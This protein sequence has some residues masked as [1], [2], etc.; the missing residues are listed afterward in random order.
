MDLLNTIAH[1]DA[2][3]LMALLDDDSIDM[4][5]TSPP[6][7]NLRTY[8]GHYEFDFE[9]IAHET[10]RVLKPGGVLVWVVGD[11]TINGSET[12]TSMRQALYFVDV[13]GFKMHDTM[14]YDKY[15]I[16]FPDTNRYHQSWEY[17][18]VLSKNTPMVFNPQKRKNLYPDDKK[19]GRQRNKD[20]TLTIPSGYKKKNKTDGW[21]FNVWRMSAGYMKTTKDKEAYAH[22]AM[23]PEKLAE[24]HILT[25]SNPGDV[26]MDYFMGSGTTAKMAR[27]NGRHYIGCDVNLEYVQ[28]ARQRLAKP[29]TLS[30]FDEQPAQD[31][32]KAEQL[33][34]FGDGE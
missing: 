26:V 28:L 19:I 15:S 31:D 18:F 25:W 2:L 23:F 11:A 20:G 27:N 17:M 7:D 14:I 12:L 13:V 1:M 10:Y 21:L 6:Y 32:S 3:S 5:I 8:N 24:R 33:T 4:A 30:M 34:L 22:P 16:V 9:A 29:Y